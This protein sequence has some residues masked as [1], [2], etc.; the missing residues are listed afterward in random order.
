MTATV[1]PFACM[2]GHP[3]HDVVCARQR[4]HAGDHRAELNDRLHTWQDPVP[5]PA[6]EDRLELLERPV[7]LLPTP[8]PL[9]L[10]GEWLET[11]L[12]RGPAWWLALAALVLLLVLAPALVVAAYRVAF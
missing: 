1:S 7:A 2:A 4:W 3:E 6:L 5:V 8:E 11:E 9:E 12:Y 10:D